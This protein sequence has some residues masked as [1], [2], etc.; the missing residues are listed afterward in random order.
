METLVIEGGRPLSGTIAIQGAKNA[1][2]P[3]LAAGMLVE[4]TVIIDRVPNLLDI[5]VMLDILRS[6]GCRAEQIGQSVVL[7]TTSANSAHIPES[8][9][10]QMRSS[11]FLMGP[12]LAR[13]GEVEV[14]Q[15]GGCAIGERKIDLHLLGLRM[16]GAEIRED[17]NRIIC[18][19]RKLTGTEIHLDFPSVGATENLMM[20]AVLADGVTTI[21][22]AAR[23]PEIEDLQHFL[24]GMGARVSGA[25]T[26][27]IRIEGVKRLV[28][29]RY[30][31]IPDRIVTGTLMI[32]AA[33]TRG[34]VTLTGANPS[35]LTSLIHVLRRAG[36]QVAADGDIIKVGGVIRPKAVERIVT[37]PYPAF[38]TDLQAQIMVL[39]ALAD[40]VSVVKEM[41]FEGRFKHV[42]ELVRM[43]ADIRVDLNSAVIRGVPRLYGTTV[44]AT[45]LR[46]GAAL[47][48]AGLAAQGKTVI[49][50]VYHIDRGYERIESMFASLGARIMRYAAVPS[51]RVIPG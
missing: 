51:N 39:L 50:H 22:N 34:Q 19:A 27:T 7:D 28:P 18:R 25:G 26:G 45:D 20:A 12:L 2:L 32:A 4:G 30:R 3:I 14:Y 16:L 35:H 21:T 17:G 8:L 6:L 44:E 23:E 41:I 47:V 38:P 36:V 24:N 13:F 48:I 33:A 29:C 10:G 1:A 37:S 11:I 15:P 43:G 46:A 9:M 31:I 49:E 40:G 42:D 5:D